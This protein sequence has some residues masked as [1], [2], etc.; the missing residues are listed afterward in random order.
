MV[1]SGGIRPTV[2]RIRKLCAGQAGCG[3]GPFGLEQA[4]V[5]LTDVTVPRDGGGLVKVRMLL[6]LLSLLVSSHGKIVII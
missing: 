3:G 4:F 6:L 1:G 2:S 5:G